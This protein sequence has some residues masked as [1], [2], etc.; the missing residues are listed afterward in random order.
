MTAAGNF[1]PRGSQQAGRM[2][3]AKKVCDEKPKKNH[4]LEEIDNSKQFV[5]RYENLYM[6]QEFS[7]IVLLVGNGRFPAHKF[8]LTT[9]S[10]VFR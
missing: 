1:L 2:A 10:N 5:Q 6:S 8:I 4:S 3:E 9:A 7:D